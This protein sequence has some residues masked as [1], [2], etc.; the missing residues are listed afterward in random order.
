MKKTNPHFRIPRELFAGM[1]WYLLALCIYWS[2][3]GMLLFFHGRNDSFRLFNSYPDDGHDKLLIYLSASS[4][5]I[6]LVSIFILALSRSRPVETILGVCCVF[7]AWYTCITI[8]YNVFSDWQSPEAVFGTAH[9]HLLKSHF[10]PELNFPSAHVVVIG[11]LSTFLAWFYRHMPTKL[12]L[13]L[14]IT[15]FLTLLPVFDGW[16]FVGDVLSGSALGTL[17][18]LLT[19][20]WLHTRVTVW[21]SR[22]NYWWQGIIIAT[23]RAFAICLL[24]VSLKYFAL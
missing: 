14:F 24:L 1:Y 13:I 16:A 6:V 8:K 5:G 15:I 4:S 10:Q 20:W 11:S 23:V 18:A 12:L 7:I 17:C 2:L 19:I 22:R 9:I 3:I 21:Y